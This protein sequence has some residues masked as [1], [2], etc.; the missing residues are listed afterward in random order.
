MVSKLQ[1]WKWIAWFEFEYS[2]INHLHN[3]QETNTV[4][5]SCRYKMPHE[6]IVT[7]KYIKRVQF[8]EDCDEDK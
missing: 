1:N 2:K 7:D 4:M 8:D 6:I 3:L 5:V